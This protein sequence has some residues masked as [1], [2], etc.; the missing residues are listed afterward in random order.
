VITEGPQPTACDPS[1]P[2][3]LAACHAMIG[4]LLGQLQ[5]AN[6]KM[7]RMEHQLEQLLRR[8]Y[9]RSAE[10]L[11]PNQLV[12]FADL[13]AQLQ[14]EAENPP[15]PES[16]AATPPAPST[17]RGHGRRRIPEDLPRRRE[18]PRPARR[19]KALSLLRQGARD[20]R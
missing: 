1:L 2:K 5:G 12:L 14:P 7:Q 11:D 20:H 3:D 13:L 9:G 6:R 8:L 15:A 17:S 19:R 10:R 18:S 4:E 16:V